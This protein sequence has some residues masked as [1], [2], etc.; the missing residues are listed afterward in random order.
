MRNRS[1]LFWSLGLALPLQ[2][3]W[4]LGGLIFTMA[5]TGVEHHAGPGA[6]GCANFHSSGLW[7]CTLG[8]ML[9]NP[10][11]AMLLLNFVTCGVLFI[12]TAS[13]IAVVLLALRSWR[14]AI[15]VNDKRDLR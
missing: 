9:L 14:G 15:S 12:V 5:S 11:M 8:E 7:P 6:F 13:A 1:I 2:Y 4:I 10:L 3:F